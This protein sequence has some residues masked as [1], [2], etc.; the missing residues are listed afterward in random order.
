MTTGGQS[1][2]KLMNLS[3]E[4]LKKFLMEWREFVPI[5]ISDKS[6]GIDLKQDHLVLTLLRRSIGRMDLVDYGIFPIPGETQ[7]EDREA[8]IISLVN[9][10][11][12]KHQIGK[13]KVSVAMPR[14]KVIARFMRL[15]VAAKQN[16]TKV[17]EYEMPKYIPFEKGEIYF[18]YCLL[19]EEKDWLRLFAVFARKTDVDPYV[20]LLKK[21]GIQP[22]SIQIP[23]V[24]ALNLFFYNKGGSENETSVLIDVTEPFLEMNLV[25]GKDWRESFHFPLPKEEKEA[26]M[27]STFK[28]SGNVYPPA[29]STFF[30][31]GLSADETILTS[32]K[33][34]NELKGALLPPM[35][36]IQGER[37]GSKPY[38]IYASIGIP[39]RGL[40]SPRVDLNLLP[41][42]MRKKVKQIGKPLLILLTFLAVFFGLTWGAGTVVHYKKEWNAV[43][44][45]IRKRRPE[46]EALEKLQKQKDDCRK[47][48]AELDQIRSGEIRKV[49]VLEE[50]TRLLPETTWIWNLKYNGKEIE[51]SGFTDSASDLIPLLDKSPLFEKVEFMAP[52]TKEMQMRGDG[53]KEK[54]RFKI[55]A[56]IEG[57]K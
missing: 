41:P 38:G 30:V 4:T 42:E 56:R 46:V 1:M 24:A 44:A 52:V 47:E 25:Q 9:T 21:M 8:Q 7:K 53:N 5:M 27:I 49:E 29:N 16:L 32:L 12:S 51:L 14:E 22:I 50:L 15:P 36:R 39:L 23:S 37:Q 43:N 35:D 54:E 19:K 31:Y 10:F 33:E 45:E 18:D 55:K 57:R 11:I 34:A 17:I 26:K 20:S 48:M 40:I 2:K 13:E 3:K 6:L 28:R